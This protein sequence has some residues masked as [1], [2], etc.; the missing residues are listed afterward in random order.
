[1]DDKKIVTMFTHPYLGLQYYLKEMIYEPSHLLHQRARIYD[2][3]VIVHGPFIFRMRI[4]VGLSK[5]TIEDDKIDV[6]RRGT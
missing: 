4:G 6:R 2:S 5:I 1:M 3:S